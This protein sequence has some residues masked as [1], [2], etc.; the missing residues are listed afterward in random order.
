MITDFA[1]IVKVKMRALPLVVMPS[2]YFDVSSR[3]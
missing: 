2:V 1:S 3:V